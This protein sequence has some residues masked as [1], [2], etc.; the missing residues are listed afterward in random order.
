MPQWAG[1]SWYFLRYCDPK[2]ESAFAG[3]EAL[4]Y[5]M[6]VD[7]YNGGME[8]VTRHM[9]YSRFW[10]RFLYDL[11]EVPYIEPYMKRSAVGLVLGADG[12]KMSKSLGNVVDPLDIAG[13]Y[14]ADTLRT[15]VCFMGDYGVASPW[16]DTG[17]KGAK[18]FLDRVAGMADLVRG[19]G[20]TPELESSFHKTVKKVSADIEE[21]KFNTAIAA[22]MSL[23]NEIYDAGTLTKDEMITFI[24]LL[25]PFAPHICEEINEKLGEKGLLSL[26]KWPEYDETKT[27]DKTVEIAL[28]VNGK[29]RGTLQI[30]ADATKEDVLA[31]AKADAR[32]TAQTEGKTIVKEIYVPGKI[33]NIVIK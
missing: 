20:S 22:L 28:Q 6:P 27:I 2:N 12:Q 26:S 14:G 29:L 17:V 1:S 31:A 3:M 7:W 25:S 13:A 8:H 19:T 9:I 21:L 33:V 23:I 24:K 16:S 5:W 11:G 32:I 18:R 4:K 15:Y 10:Y 30:D